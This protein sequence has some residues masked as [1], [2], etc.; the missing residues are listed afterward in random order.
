MFVDP[1]CRGEKRKGILFVHP[2]QKEIAFACADIK[3]LELPDDELR[4]MRA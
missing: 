3:A 1:T 2:A 4:Q